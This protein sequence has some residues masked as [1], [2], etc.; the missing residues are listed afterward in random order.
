MYF[1]FRSP[2]AVCL[3]VNIL[4][5]ALQDIMR[6]CILLSVCAL[7]FILCFVFVD[8]IV[9]LLLR[10]IFLT[11]W[12]F[13]LCFRWATFMNDSARKRYILRTVSLFYLRC[14]TELYAHIHM[15]DIYRDILFCTLLYHNTSLLYYDMQN[16]YT[17]TM[18]FNVLC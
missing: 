7:P 10:C 2:L 8:T 1:E 17:L 5:N 6:E 14:T 13:P 4:S 12:F 11:I 9:L 18:N 15:I 16:L 3:R